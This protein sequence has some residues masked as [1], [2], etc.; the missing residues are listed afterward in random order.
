MSANC[1]KRLG[2]CG[3]D[4]RTEALQVTG[5]R[6]RAELWPDDPV[7]IVR[8]LEMR[9][10]ERDHAR[11]P[12]R[13]ATRSA[14]GA[15]RE[16]PCG[17]GAQTAKGRK[18]KMRRT[19]PGLRA[20][21]RP[22]PTKMKNRQSTEMALREDFG[23]RH[24]VSARP[25]ADSGFSHPP[26]LGRRSQAPTRLRCASARLLQIGNRVASA[27]QTAEGGPKVRAAGRSIRNSAARFAAR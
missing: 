6:A 5:F 15:V 13:I 24:V 14:A 16:R 20:F 2:K 17:R 18:T 21:L 26:L 25:T 22:K 9:A 23:S 27:R 1:G 10:L 12:A 4:R 7:V 8:E 3:K 11:R 19:L